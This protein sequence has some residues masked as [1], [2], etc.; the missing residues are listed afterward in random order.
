MSA[1]GYGLGV[2]GGKLEMFAAGGLLPGSEVKTPHEFLLIPALS[3]HITIVISAHR[4]PVYPDLIAVLA[5]RDVQIC[6]NV[7][8]SNRGRRRH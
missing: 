6:L 8:A 4:V 7:A 5:V 2:F 1:L 3:H